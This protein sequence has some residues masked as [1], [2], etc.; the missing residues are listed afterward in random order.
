MNDHLPD[1]L[2]AIDAYKT[3]GNDVN[4][5]TATERTTAWLKAYCDWVDNGGGDEAI[6]V[7]REDLKQLGNNRLGLVNGLKQE[8]DINERFNQV[9][10]PLLDKA[11]GPRCKHC[12]RPA[13]K[14][15]G[16]WDTNYTSC[17]GCGKLVMPLL[18][19]DPPLTEKQQRER[20]IPLVAT[21]KRADSEAVEAINA[22]V[23]LAKAAPSDNDPHT[24]AAIQAAIPL[25]R[26]AAD[27]YKRIY[28]TASKVGYAHVLDHAAV[29]EGDFETFIEL[30][31]DGDW[32]DLVE[33]LEEDYATVTDDEYRHL[34]MDE[35]GLV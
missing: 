15:R 7:F 10:R 28:D 24:A 18:P 21:A 29:S 3:S 19:D 31:E 5:A 22:A 13:P 32:G 9:V 34:M 4:K 16:S 33:Q 30:A 25:A 20:L 17:M 8:T 12:R 2:D 11:V 26:T 23:A 6:R 14:S 27:A 1:L 35:L